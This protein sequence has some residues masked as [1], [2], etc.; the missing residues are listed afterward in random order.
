MLRYVCNMSC[1]GPENCSRNILI[2]FLHTA[3]NNSPG[4]EVWFPKLLVE[5]HQEI[6]NFRVSSQHALSSTLEL[7]HNERAK[8]IFR[9]L[10]E[11]LGSSGKIRIETH[12][13]NSDILEIRE[14]YQVSLSLD[15]K[16]VEIIGKNN[17]SLDNAEILLIE[18][19]PS[20]VSE[21][22]KILETAFRNKKQLILIARSFPE[23]VSSTLAVN[24][25]KNKLSVIPMIYGNELENINS[26]SDIMAISSGIPISKD[27]GDTLNV[28]IENKLG[29][30]YN[31][32]IK[33]NEITCH[34]DV[35]IS[36]HVNR[37]RRKIKETVAGEEDKS[38]LLF[39]RLAGLTNNML[40]VKLRDTENV[41]L[42]KEEL[43]IAIS[44][45]NAFCY[46]ASRIKIGDTEIVM[47]KR[48][49]DTAKDLT[50]SYEK[51]I[52]SIGG[53]LILE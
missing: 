24:W 34:T 40:T 16:F 21:I 50:D 47:P 2:N 10:I 39:S 18:G 26:H 13:I 31:V 6:S 22:N 28:D 46:R 49:Y 14:G 9:T 36:D 35:D 30:V 12:K 44:Y 43:E 19:A 11:L 3:Y 5:K 20:G 32:N 27:L 4:S 38:T 33:Q 7:M 8:N 25:L 52:K 17:F 23:E 53:F 1:N 29:Y 15:R 45:F 41:F 51:T 48:I 37:I 42:V